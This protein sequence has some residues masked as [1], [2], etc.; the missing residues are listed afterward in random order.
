[1]AHHPVRGNKTY[2]EYIGNAALR[3]IG[4]K[5]WNK[6][7]ARIIAILRTVVQFDHLY[8]GGGN[9]RHV[10]S[11]LPP[12]VSAVPN[13]DGLT[14]GIGLWREPTLGSLPEATAAAGDAG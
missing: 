10:A 6:R 4:K 5:R 12:D 11:P 3:K 9:A 14:G 13:T 1:L 8:L 2:D 7:V